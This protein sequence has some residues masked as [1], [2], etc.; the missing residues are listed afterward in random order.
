MIASGWPFTG[1]HPSCFHNHVA[2][3]GAVP[4]GFCCGGFSSTAGYDPGNEAQADA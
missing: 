3:Y 4:L 2:L 1:Q